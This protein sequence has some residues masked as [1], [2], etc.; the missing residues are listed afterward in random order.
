[1]KRFGMMVSI[2]LVLVLCTAL[3]CS[4]AN[5]TVE[6]A[7]TRQKKG[8][9]Q[10]EPRS[11]DERWM[12]VHAEYTMEVEASRGQVGQG[13]WSRVARASDE[14]TGRCGLPT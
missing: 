6:T 14:S 8:K 7:S 10:A 13:K 11:N 4:C 9:V 2:A 5:A 12:R 1:M 3:C